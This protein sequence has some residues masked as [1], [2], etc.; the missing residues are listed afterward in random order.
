MLLEESEQSRTKM[1]RFLLPFSGPA[2]AET[3]EEHIRVGSRWLA[4]AQRNYPGVPPE[5]A[6]LLAQK[7]AGLLDPSSVGRYRADLRYTLLAEMTAS[8]RQSA[9][10]AAWKDIDAALSDRKAKIPEDKWR[11]SARKVEDATEQEAAAL[12]YE[13]KRHG[14]K[15]KNPNTILAA[16]FVLVAGHSGFR[17]IE[18]RGASFDGTWLTLP[19]AKKRPGHPPTRRLDLS[20]LHKDVRTG[21]DL[22]LAMIDH[23]LSKR[24]FAKW[25][26]CLAGQ[27]QRACTRIGIRILSLY[28]FRHIAIASWSASG[29]SAEEIALLCGHLSIN[30]A[31]SHY[32]RAKVGHKR[33]AV[34]RADVA[35]TLM[36]AA[37]ATA[38]AEVSPRSSLE[39]SR[40]ATEKADWR[41]VVEDMPV[42]VL[43]KADPS[44]ALAPAEVQ[45]YFNRL[46][47]PRSAEEIGAALRKARRSAADRAQD[48]SI[49]DRQD[50]KNAPGP[51]KSRKP[52]D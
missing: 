34:A 23:D 43:K 24:E 47:D 42:P 9:F 14:L 29:L 18:L 26:K 51:T 31:H 25:Q 49:G 38:G 41:F 45:S 8:G 28:S 19:N 10:S 50:S 16:L 40:P 17:P 11:T 52:P 35:P 32:A 22:L 20:G 46:V 12:F 30:T 39:P 21:M 1:P 4:A 36:T 5:E 3:I 37:Q 6:L 27:L 33:K 2:A 15:H 7:A 48:T 44:D 13:L